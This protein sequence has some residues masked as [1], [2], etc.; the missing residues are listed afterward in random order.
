MGNANELLKTAMA[1]PEKSN[2]LLAH[3]PTIAVLQKKK[4]TYR[5]IAD[6]LVEQ[7]VAVTYPTLFRFV[8]ANAAKLGNE[9]AAMN[10]ANE[11][12]VPTAAEYSK[13]LSSIQMSQ[14]QRKMLA[15]HYRAHNRSVTY[16]EL[17]Q[18][19]GSDSHRT[20]NAHYGSLGRTLGEK[21]N[22]EFAVNEYTGEPFYSS[23]IGLG[24]PYKR[25][26][27]EFLLV[28][29]HEL[30]DALKELGVFEGH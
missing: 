11:I 8:K 7:G 5:E 27:T 18:A 23:S 17:A 14:I 19:V 25:N 21:L 30:S 4:Y 1:V 6:F 10:A 20:A 13:A 24:A 15:A 28:M 16:S 9:G 29:H 3:L 22:F 26:D 2:L 12:K